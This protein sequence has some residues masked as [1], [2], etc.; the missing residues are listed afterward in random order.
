MGTHSITATYSG[1]T[2]SG[3]STGSTTLTVGPI[4]QQTLVDFL[5][6]GGRDDQVIADILGSKEYFQRAQ[7][8]A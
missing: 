1:T 7:T 4:S 5:L 2:N 3:L 6:R 8:V